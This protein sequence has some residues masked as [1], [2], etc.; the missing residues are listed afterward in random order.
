MDM[1]Y[2]GNLRNEMG[3]TSAEKMLGARA[4]KVVLAP[5]DVMMGNDGSLPLVL[6]IF[7]S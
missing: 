3:P 1:K 4:G 6:R 5:V 7:I 2:S